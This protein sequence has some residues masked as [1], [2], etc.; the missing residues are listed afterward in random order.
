VGRVRGLL[1]GATLEQG[2]PRATAGGGAFKR[3]RPVAGLK[4]QAENEQVDVAKG[5]NDDIIVGSVLHLNLFR[6]SGW[7]QFVNCGIIDSIIRKTSIPSLPASNCFPSMVV[8][9]F[10]R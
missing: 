7:R 9:F 2:Q 5:N 4:V 10:V 6:N 8:R 1:W 3:D